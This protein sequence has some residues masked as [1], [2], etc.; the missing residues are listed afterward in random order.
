MTAHEYDYFDQYDYMFGR[1]KDPKLD[2]A[3]A[4]ITRK[5]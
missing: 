3:A 1:G 2:Q 5:D 4:V